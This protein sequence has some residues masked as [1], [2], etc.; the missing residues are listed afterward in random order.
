MSETSV[1]ESNLF[2]TKN[3]LNLISRNIT[4]NHQIRKFSEFVF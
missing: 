2:T 1:L 3:Y 4:E